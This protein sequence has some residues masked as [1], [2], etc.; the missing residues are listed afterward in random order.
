MLKLIVLLECA[1]VGACESAN[2][3]YLFPKEDR[4]QKQNAYI[5]MA[6]FICA[7]AK[8]SPTDMRSTQIYT[9]ACVKCTHCIHFIDYVV[10]NLISISNTKFICV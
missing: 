4:F 6:F 3:F 9:N 10:V 5:Y 8:I 1:Q 2:V 7:K